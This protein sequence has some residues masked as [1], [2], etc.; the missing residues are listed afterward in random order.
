MR[1]GYLSCT[2]LNIKKMSTFDLSMKQ[3]T[4]R[5]CCD[6]VAHWDKEEPEMCWGFGYWDQAG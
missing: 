4:I 6:M 2:S 1:D 3:P 5:K